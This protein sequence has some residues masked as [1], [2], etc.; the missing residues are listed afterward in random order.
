[1]STIRS[2]ELSWENLIAFPFQWMTGSTDLT[3]WLVSCLVEG[4]GLSWVQCRTEEAWPFCWINN[5]KSNIIYCS[6]LF[7]LSAKRT[8]SY[9][10]VCEKDTILYYIFL[11]S[12][13]GFP[14]IM[15]AGLGLLWLYY[16]ML[17]LHQAK[18]IKEYE[19]NLILKLCFS[20]LGSFY[21]MT[22]FYSN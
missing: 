9:C 18:K 3:G 14:S 20:T 22:W 16:A 1:M 8:C 10:F 4:I 11:P 7:I 5:G 6:P 21:V 15:Y 17:W 2:Y 13:S 19:R 12:F